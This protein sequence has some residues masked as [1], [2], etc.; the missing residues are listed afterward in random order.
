[1][2]TLMPDAP[3]PPLTDL[4]AHFM[5][6]GHMEELVAED[7]GGAPAR[8]MNIPWYLLVP[9]AWA[10]YFLPE[11]TAPGTA[12]MMVEKLVLMLADLAP[13]EFYQAWCRTAC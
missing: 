12:L 1:M 6:Q 11:P 3:V 10:P 9:T 5:A 7:I 13:A 8:T 4:A 2:L